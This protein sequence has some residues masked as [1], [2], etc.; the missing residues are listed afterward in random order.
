MP[1]QDKIPSCKLTCLFDGMNIGGT[2]HDTD[3][4]ILLTAGIG[5]NRALFLFRECPA[6]LTVTNFR[7]G[8]RQCL[9]QSHSTTAISLQ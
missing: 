7:H 1:H 8:S 3:L 5:A 2:F 6:I 4:T 9:C